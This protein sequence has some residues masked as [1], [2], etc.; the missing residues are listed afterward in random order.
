[1][2]GKQHSPDYISSAIHHYKKT[3]NYTETC[4]V[5]VKP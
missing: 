2:V 1:M 5:F 3:E 4:D